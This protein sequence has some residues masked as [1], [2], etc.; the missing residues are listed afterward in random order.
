MPDTSNRPDLRRQTRWPALRAVLML[1]LT[2]F[3]GSAHAAEFDEKL[4]SPVMKNATELRT[5]MQTFATKF[6]DIRAA[7]PAQLVTNA[8]LARQQF[9][10]IW[11]VQQAIDMR[12]PLDELAEVGIVSLGEGRYGVDMGAYPQWNEIAS[13]FIAATLPDNLQY[14]VS[15]LI[16][17]GFRP[18]DVAT[19]KRYLDEHDFRNVSSATNLSVSLGFARAVRKYDEQKRSVPDSL[20]FSYWY[21][22]A[23][24]HSEGQRS[25][26]EGLLKGFDA[27]RQRIFLSLIMEL[28]PYSTW[29]PDDIATGIPDLLAQVRM[30]DF[31][32][33][34]IAEAKGVAP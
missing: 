27:Q 5:Q 9:D 26:A 30:P 22:R 14:T 15:A 2:G 34:I 21:Q 19:L 12:K 11:Q 1:A 16:Q 13:S 8:T 17:R 23:R 29:S 31:E 28:N 6:R 24:Y 18:E 3:T 32:Q 20:V 4:K 7:T 33:R 25:W 10:L